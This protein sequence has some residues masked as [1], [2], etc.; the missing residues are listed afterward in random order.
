[1]TPYRALERAIITSL[2]LLAAYC[3][4]S[5]AAWAQS[6]VSA[7]W[8]DSSGNWTNSA[9]WSCGVTLAPCVPNN[10]GGNS[11]N[12][13]F[14]SPGNTVT[15]D[16]TSRP[17][18]VTIDAL[19]LSDGTLAIGKTGALNV[20]N[21]L[22]IGNSAVV[23][24][25]PGGT[26]QAGSLSNLQFSTV[27]TGGTY[28]IGGS[29]LFP[30]IITQI[31]TDTS[32][33]LE[34]SSAVFGKSTGIVFSETFDNEGTLVLNNHSLNITTQLLNSGTVE[35]QNSSSLTIAPGS[36]NYAGY[37]NS[38]TVGSV[39]ALIDIESGSSLKVYGGFG[40]GGSVIMGAKGLNTLFV[41]ANVNLDKGGTFSMKG[42]LDKVTSSGFNN[43]GSTVSI[44]TGASVT[45][46]GGGYGGLYHQTAGTTDVN[47]TLIAPQ[48]EI[49]AGELSGT[50]S[51]KAPVTI[52]VDATLD[53]GQDPG[54]LHI[55]GSLE[56]AG[57]LDETIGSTSS[58]SVTD[59][60]GELKLGSGSALS[61][62]LSPNF[63]PA[64]GTTFTI[65]DFSSLSPG[66]QFGSI[67]NQF[68]N[69]H[70]EKWSVAYNSTDI[71]LTAESSTPSSAPEPGSLLL[72]CTGLGAMAWLARRRWVVGN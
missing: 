65:L 56:V 3:V 58:F 15:L 29:F 37:L 40:S 30:G 14:N 20:I 61:V 35:L 26:L 32:L 72:L 39:P 46:T 25:A 42:N 53:P 69:D 50:G 49:D 68:F 2:G 12:V 17:S 1:M 10:G 36:T 9:N 19:A 4:M 11:F 6:T 33:T 55:D 62:L 48:V 41:T 43:L 16:N 23:Q 18:S 57:A 38:Y 71:V 13:T 5:S 64:V 34:G 31:G 27:L 21:A 8:T 22:S 45:V 67:V 28:D 66:S 7:S 47:G 52:G 54:H 51:I 59:I 24:V 63:A 44:A 60:T 70:S